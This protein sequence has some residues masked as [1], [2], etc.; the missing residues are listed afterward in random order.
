MTELEIR[1]LFAELVRFIGVRHGIDLRVN[2]VIDHQGDYPKPR[3]FAK[4]SGSAIFLS[5]KIIGCGKG[6]VEGLLCHELGH[7]LL[8]QVGDYDHSERYADE[9]AELCFER[10][11]YYDIE[12]VQTTEGGVRPRPPHLPQ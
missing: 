1:D 8:M 2:L 12:G 10:H 4:T 11:I 9:I 5:P 7:V 6:R 3:D